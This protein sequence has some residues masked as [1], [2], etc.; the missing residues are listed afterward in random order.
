ILPN[1]SCAAGCQHTI[2]ALPLH[3]PRFST[4]YPAKA[5]SGGLGTG[6]THMKRTLDC[7]FYCGGHGMRYL[8]F[9]LIDGG[10]SF[11]DSYM[12]LG[13]NESHR[14]SWRPQLLRE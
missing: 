10:A 3:F 11:R 12:A 1:P 2:T 8:G 4:A 14:V 13:G 7:G 9:T 5:L 6:I